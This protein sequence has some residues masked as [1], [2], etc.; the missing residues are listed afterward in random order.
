MLRKFICHMYT[1]LILRTEIH[2]FQKQNHQFTKLM[3]TLL[4]NQVKRLGKF[5]TTMMDYTS[6]NTILNYFFSF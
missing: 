3:T 6:L 5:K 1:G 4:C 2:V